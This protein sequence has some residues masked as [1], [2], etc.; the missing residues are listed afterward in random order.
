MVGIRAAVG[1][2]IGAAAAAV[3]AVLI[4]P[5]FKPPLVGVGFV[6]ANAYPKGWDYAVIALLVVGA[7]AGAW[8]ALSRVSSAATPG[9][10]LPEKRGWHLPATAAAVFVL[11]LVVHDHPFQHMDPFHEGEHLTPA[12][13]FLQGERPYVDVF[14]LHGLGVDGGLDALVGGRPLYTRRLQTVLDAATLALLVFIAAEVTA[15][16]TGMIAAVLA[17]L[18]GVAAFWVPV[19]PYFRLAPVLL[20]AIGLLRYARTGRAGP[21]LVAFASATLGVLWSLDTGT[22]ALAGTVGAFILLPRRLPSG[23]AAILA[24]VAL[25]LPLLV[26]VAVRADVPQFVRDS[27]VIIPTAIDA[28]WSLPAPKPLTAAG[29]RYFL[30]PILYGMMLAVGWKRRDARVIILIVLS[31][32]LFRTAAGRV[33]WSHTRFA[34]PLLG[35]AFVAFVLEPLKQR[36]LM[37]VLAL[38]AVFYF[39]LPQNAVAGAKLIAEWPS[40][41]RPQGLVRHPLVSGIY[42][43]EENATQLATLKNYVDALGPG[44]ILD[45]TN[46]RALYFLLRRRPP[47]RTFDIPMLSSHQLLKPAMAELQIHPPVCVILGGEPAVAVFDGVRNDDRVPELYRWVNANYTK[48][49]EIG[50]FIVA[51]R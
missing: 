34:T 43:S 22:Y 1:S 28:V 18:C 29:L 21:L 35:I 40:R 15:T 41:Q 24:A 11:M 31:V 25:A 42:T 26:L 50:R 48:R 20:A 37:T 49:T 4:R 38:A 33:S 7:F 51:T 13:L 32:I 27:F 3:A 10:A 45:L 2:L 5:F 17:S 8:L 9:T 23:R 44:P 30:P 19:F 36:V 46:E 47:M 14:L 39:E 16:S 6:T 12:W